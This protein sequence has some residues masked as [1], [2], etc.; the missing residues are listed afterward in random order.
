MTRWIVN[1]E[2]EMMPRKQL[3]RDLKYSQGISL[4][5]PKKIYLLRN[6]EI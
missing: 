3:R 4:E 2:P 6:G 1:N 5:G